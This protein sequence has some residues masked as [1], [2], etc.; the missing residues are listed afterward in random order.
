MTFS[1]LVEDAYGEYF[2]PMFFRKKKEEKIL[3]NIP[4]LRKIKSWNQN[5]LKLNKTIINFIKSK[6]DFVLLIL[7]GEG[8]DIA[9]KISELKEKIKQEYHDKLK[10]Y[11]FD[12]EI[13]E[14]IC[15]MLDLKYDDKPSK[16]LKHQEKY[17]KNKLPRYAE[18]MDCKKLGDCQSYVRFLDV[19]T[20]KHNIT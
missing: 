12:Y 4:N 1:C 7:D 11:F 9:R 18:K 15:H 14:W 16:I 10:I 17:E 19:L 5:I 13:E 6:D 3:D 20:T 8:K 2:W